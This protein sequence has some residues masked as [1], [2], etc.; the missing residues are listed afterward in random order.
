MRTITLLT[1]ALAATGCA[2]TL[3]KPEG[4][5][6]EVLQLIFRDGNPADEEAED[7]LLGAI[8]RLDEDEFPRYDLTGSVNSRT[9]APAILTEEFRDGFA[10]PTGLTG[11]DWDK[12]Q[13]GSPDEDCTEVSENDQLPVAVFGE[14]AHDLTTHL[15]LIADTNQA[16]IGS[17]STKFAE[18]TW[19]TDVDCFVD[20][21]CNTATS[22]TETRTKTI[23]AKVWLDINNDYFRT[24]LPDGREVVVSRGWTDKIF[25]SDSCSQSWD[26]RFTLDIWLP[27]AD[28]DSKTRR[29]YTMW[30]SANISGVEDDFYVS[31]VKGG[32]Q[33]S[34]DNADSFA[35]G[36]TC[37]DRDNENTRTDDQDGE[38]C[39]E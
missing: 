23:I 1:L 17:D 36:D 21:S 35:D 38:E 30:S 25:W 14:S 2:K 4:D 33:E 32:I 13:G 6:S 20:G 39:H 28:D 12:C 5:L 19:T 11:T 34:Y 15:D 16:C 10:V 29:L 22:T 8:A 27:D 9:V 31:L 7:R 37:G 24:E 3:D 18:K 26:Q